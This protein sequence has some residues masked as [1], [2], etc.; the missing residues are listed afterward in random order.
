MVVK[1]HKLSDLLVP[2]G[3][4]RGPFGSSLKRSDMLDSGIPVYEQMNA[5]YDHREF[6]YYI[7]EDKFNELKRFKVEPGDLILSCSGTVGRITII[8]ESDP[9]GIISQALLILR[10]DPSIVLP[11]YLKNFFMTKKGLNSLLERSIGSVQ[12]NIAKREV[13]ENI[14]VPIPSLD[15]QRN[16]ISILSSLDHK[17]NLLKSINDNLGGLVLAS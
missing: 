17:I 9:T 10:V 1:I 11:E 12:V 3:Y 14:E 13:I 8:K 2:K 15:S 6:R 5:I 4:I 7:D 16:S